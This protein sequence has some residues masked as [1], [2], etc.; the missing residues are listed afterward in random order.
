[1]VLDTFLEAEVK[2]TSIAFGIIAGRRSG[3]HF[4]LANLR[5]TVGAKKINEFL[6]GE[7]GLTVVDINLDSSFSYDVDSALRH[8]QAGYI[9][10]EKQCITA[11][12]GNRVSRIKAHTDNLTPDNGLGG[13]HSHLTHRYGQV[14]QYQ[15]A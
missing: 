7:F 6:T 12:A 5:S 4:Y 10:K 8:A 1:M 11:Y 14:F 2:D 3:N 15:T 13:C 9:E